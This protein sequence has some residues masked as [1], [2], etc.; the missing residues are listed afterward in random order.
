MDGRQVAVV[1]ALRQAQGDKGA[2]DVWIGSLV[3]TGRWHQK[4]EIRNLQIQKSSTPP[5][6]LL[7]AKPFLSDSG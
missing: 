1:S 6:L 2:R 7:C 3:E 5:F 4:P